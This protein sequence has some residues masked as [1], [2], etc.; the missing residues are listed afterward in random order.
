MTTISDRIETEVLIE[1]PQARVWRAISNAEEFGKWFQV[2]LTGKEFAAG[3]TVSARISSCG[4]GDL[5]WTVLVER[6]EPEQ[7]FS[8]RWHPYSKDSSVDYS[9]EERTL[10]EF[11][12]KEV[13]NGTLLTVIESGFDKVPPERRLEAFRMNTRGWAAKIEDVEKYATTS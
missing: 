7:L 6:I 8:F 9:A 13:D 2:D 4:H 1:A 5:P 12:L 10:V 3:Q 11:R